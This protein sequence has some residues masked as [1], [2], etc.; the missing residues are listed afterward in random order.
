MN[1]LKFLIGGGEYGAATSALLQYAIKPPVLNT[2]ARS[3]NPVLTDAF[4]VSYLRYSGRIEKSLTFK[5][6]NDLVMA[7]NKLLKFFEEFYSA[8]RSC[9]YSH[10]KKFLED[11]YWASLNGK[12]IAPLFYL[13]SE[14]FLVRRLIPLC[15]NR[16]IISKTDFMQWEKS[17]N[18]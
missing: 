13:N 9:G 8:F 1:L 18:L 6:R 12:T 16:G 11:H 4:K 14:E 3:K 17:N 2:P 10:P 7:S 15:I 5:E